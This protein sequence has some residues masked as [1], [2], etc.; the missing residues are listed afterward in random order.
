MLDS[1][2]QMAAIIFKSFDFETE[3]YPSGTHNQ[4]FSLAQ[5]FLEATLD[6][7]FKKILEDSKVLTESFAGPVFREKFQ[8]LSSQMSGL[9]PLD[10]VPGPSP[11]TST[12][13]AK[14]G[15]KN[16]VAPKPRMKIKAP[17]DLPPVPSSWSIPAAASAVASSS[18]TVVPRGTSLMAGSQVARSISGGGM[19][20]SSRDDDHRSISSAGASAERLKRK[21]NEG[22]K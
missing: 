18:R 4:L 8:D 5:E 17:S 14:R 21:R 1:V 20:V 6:P 2:A 9:G 16:P 19:S 13:P 15:K 3:E 22:R 12:P 11:S 10:P 7:R